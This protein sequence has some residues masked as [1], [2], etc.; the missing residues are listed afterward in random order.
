MK[1]D[2]FKLWQFFRLS[3]KPGTWVEANTKGSRN[4]IALLLIDWKRKQ[5]QKDGR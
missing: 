5:Y 4:D 3:L 2:T 1:H